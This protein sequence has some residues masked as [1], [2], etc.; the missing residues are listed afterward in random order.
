MRDIKEI[1]VFS[2]G[3][4]NKI[5]TWSNVPYFFTTT[6]EKKG[7]KVNRIDLSPNRIVEK[8]FDETVSRL[9]SVI[10]KD[11][12]YTYFRSFM[13]FINV[14]Y[15]IKKSIK[16]FPQSDALIFLT[17]TFSASQLTQKPTIQFCDWTYDHFFNYFQN[18]KPNFFELQSVKREN[19]Q[20][21]GSNLVIPLFPSVA[22]YMKKKYT[23]KIIYLGN[24]INSVYETIDYE[25]LKIKN[26]S[27]KILF[28][29]S[30]KYMEGAQL[31]LKAFNKLK[32][33]HSALSLH[34]IGLTASN[35]INLPKDVYCYGYL[36]KG[37]EKQRDLYYRLLKEA[38][39]FVNTTPKWSAFSASLE[40]MYFY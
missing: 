11:N 32:L 30:P 33:S 9:L 21:N 39:I 5:S 23:S 35:F 2:V 31:L 10:N 19:S 7:V 28:I 36:D 25:I 12:T 14:R 18:R 29:G 6:F 1:T 34:F 16:Q 22:E 40:A 13:H 17:F 4:S 38:K 15:K 3:D 20:I 26:H 24:V 8:I 37:D 27:N